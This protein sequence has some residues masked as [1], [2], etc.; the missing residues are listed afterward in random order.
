MTRFR[1]R[2]DKPTGFGYSDLVIATETEGSEDWSQIIANERGRAAINEMIDRPIDWEYGGIESVATRL[3]AP[4]GWRIIEIS[5]A[6]Y[7]IAGQAA[8]VPE[9]E[10]ESRTLRTSL[11]LAMGALRA[12]AAPCVVI[13][14]EP[15]GFSFV[16]VE[17]NKPV[18]VIID[19][20]RWKGLNSE[21]SG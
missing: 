16:K 4:A 9:V 19:F 2:S 13:Y 20:D 7:E 10:A 3:G 1:L 17:D 14:D 11:R 15:I 5:L 6:R 8:R 21:A 18:T 12:R